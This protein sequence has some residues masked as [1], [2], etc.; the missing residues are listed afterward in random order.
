M[1]ILVHPRTLRTLHSRAWRQA[2]Q[3][4]LEDLVAVLVLLRDDAS[5]KAVDTAAAKL[6]SKHLKSFK[7]PKVRQYGHNPKV[8]GAPRVWTIAGDD[9]VIILKAA[10]KQTHSTS[11]NN[12]QVKPYLARMTDKPTRAEMLNLGYQDYP[13]PPKAAPKSKAPLKSKWLPIIQRVAPAPVEPAPVALAPQASSTK[14]PKSKHTVADFRVIERKDYKTIQAW[15]DDILDLEPSLNAS[16]VCAIGRDQGI[17]TWGPLGGCAHRAN[18]VISR[19]R[20]ARGYKTRLPQGNPRFREDYPEGGWPAN[21]QPPRA[22]VRFDPTSK[23]W[24]KRG[25]YADPEVWLIDILEQ[26]ATLNAEKIVRL[27][28]AQNVRSGLSPES[29]RV[30]ASS[31]LRTWRTRRGLPPFPRGNPKLVGGPKG[32]YAANW[33]PD[34]L[35]ELATLVSPKPYGA[36]NERG[37]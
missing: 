28:E 11:W 29:K 25:N 30:W 32:G 27:T 1:D 23:L 2:H 4:F 5:R 33:L 13:L 16:E 15:F 3:S 36:K 14:K 34:D 37:T 12:A 24:V 22:N 10:E 21:W 26:D 9:C 6:S 7:R 19:W 18:A 35:K 31:Q 17:W 20:K 8:G